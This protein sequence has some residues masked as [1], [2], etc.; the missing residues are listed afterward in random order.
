MC[1]ETVHIT[2]KVNI[3]KGGTYNR[4][5]KRR[6]K[7]KSKTTNTPAFLSS[8]ISPGWLNLQRHVNLMAYFFIWFF[9]FVLYIICMNLNQ[10]VEKQC[11]RVLSY[12]KQGVTEWWWQW[13]ASESN[14]VTFTVIWSQYNW[15]PMEDFGPDSALFK[16]HRKTKWGNIYCKNGAHPST[17][18]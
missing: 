5:Y 12:R 18:L 6:S 14:A 16:H 17:D 11:M 9:I 10:L 8:I 7:I 15:T 4:M 1:P 2:K 13:R 3:V